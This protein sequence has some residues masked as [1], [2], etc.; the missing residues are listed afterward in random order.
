MKSDEYIQLV[1]SSK[2]IATKINDLETIL[3][4]F[5]ELRKLHE[6]FQNKLEY[7]I[8]D[9]VSYE[10]PEVREEIR[11]HAIEIQDLCRE[12]NIIS[13]FVKLPNDWFTF[14]SEYNCNRNFARYYY[15]GIEIT[16]LIVFIKKKIFKRAKPTEELRNMEFQ[17]YNEEKSFIKENNDLPGDF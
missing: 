5:D 10:S 2:E 1:K 15:G 6:K 3:P 11:R 17:D 12:V 13:K 16:N 4:Y 7:L 8:I 14:S 9:N